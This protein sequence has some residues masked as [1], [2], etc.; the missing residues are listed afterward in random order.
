MVKK[1]D[2]VDVVSLAPFPLCMEILYK[3][4]T[5]IKSGLDAEGGTFSHEDLMGTEG[6]AGVHPSTRAFLGH[7]CSVSL[8]SHSSVMFI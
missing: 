4:V 7:A 2:R 1:Q 3:N 8:L 6:F 5:R